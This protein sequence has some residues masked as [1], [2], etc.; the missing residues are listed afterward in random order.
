MAESRDAL[1]QNLI[2]LAGRIGRTY[3]R[4]LNRELAARGVSDSMALPILYLWRFGSMR[5]GVLADRLGVQG[6]SLARQV[7]LLSAADLIARSEDGRDRRSKILSLTERGSA[8]ASVI[9]AASAEIRRQMLGSVSDEELAVTVEVLSHFKGKIDEK[10]NGIPID[11][12][13]LADD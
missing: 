11:D 4:T 1:E 13:I 2:V 9:A 6:P 10:L 3:R 5:Q 8:L 12:E 7:E